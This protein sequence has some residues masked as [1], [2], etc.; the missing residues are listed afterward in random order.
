MTTAPFEHITCE[1]EGNAMKTSLSEFIGEINR[2][3]KSGLLSVTVKGANSLLKLFFRQGEIYHLTFGNCKG[4]GCLEQVVGVELA[5]YFFMPDVSLTVQDVDLPPLSA[6]IELLRNHGPIQ[7]IANPPGA[8][9]AKKAGGASV[10]AASVQERLKMALVRQI[11]PAGAKVMTK[12]VEQKWHASPTPSREDLT[13]LVELLKKEIE[14]AND[15][16]EFMKEAYTII[17]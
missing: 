5:E 15:Q 13:R 16:N 10:D 17:S 2:T 8:A 12:I 3:R 6:I 1:E 14:N 9:T 7:E 4:P 11:G